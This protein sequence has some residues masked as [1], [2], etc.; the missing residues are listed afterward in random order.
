MFFLD[1]LDDMRLYRRSVLLPINEKDKRH[2]CAAFLLSPNVDSL[3]DIFDNALLLPR[4]YNCYYT[5]KA[6]MYYINQ[7]NVVKEFAS[8][9][10]TEDAYLFDEKEFK[11]HIEGYSHQVG[12]VKKYLK[13]SWFIKQFNCFSVNRKKVNKDINIIIQEGNSNTTKDMIFLKPTTSYPKQFKSYDNYCYFNAYMWIFYQMNPNI[14]DWLCMGL[15]LKEAGVSSMYSRS[16][17]PFNHNLGIICRALDRYEEEHSRIQYINDLIRADDGMNK[18]KISIRDLLSLLSKDIQ[19]SLSKTFHFEGTISVSDHMGIVLEDS[20]YNTTFKKMLYS[21]RIKSNKELMTFYEMIK[22]RYPEIK[23]C[24]NNLSLYGKRNLFIDLSYYNNAFIQ[25]CTAIKIK[26][27]NLYIDLLKRLFSDKRFA[28]AGYDKQTVII[29]VDS[30]MRSIGGVKDF[31]LI[32]KTINPISVIFLILSNNYKRLEDIFG[33]REVLFL[34]KSSFMKVNFSKIDDVKKQMFL[35]NIRIIAENK[36]VLDP[37]A[38]VG[39]AAVSSAKAIKMTIVDN[40]EKARKI[41]IDNISVDN[42]DEEDEDGIPNIKVEDIPDKEPTEDDKKKQELVKV[43]DKASKSQ[44]SVEDTLDSIDANKEDAERIKNIISDLATNPDNGGNNISGARASR[45]LKLQNDFMDSE[46]EGKSIKDILDP[47]QSIE[48]DIKPISL[49]IDSINPEWKELKFAAT[50]ESYNLDDDIVRIFSSFNDKSNPLVVLSLKKDDTSTSGNIIDTYTCKYESAKGE[51]FTVKVD[52]PRF[53]DNK[54]MVLRGN[55]KNIPIQIFLMPIIKTQEDTVQIVSCY[56]KI[57]IRRFGTTSGKSNPCTDKLM[58]ALRKEYKHI[59]I[60][61]G[62]N[63]RVCSKYEVPI[64][65]VDLAGEYT[66]IETPMYVFM[67]NQDQIHSK[68]DI[69]DSDGLCIGYDK[70]SKNP[71]FFKPD[72]K[73][74]MF[75]SQYI[76]LMM[77]T[78]LA[79]TNERDTFIENFNNANTAVRYTFSRAKVM[80]SEIPLI[81]ICALAEGLEKVMRKAHIKYELSEKRPKYDHST[82]DIIRFKDGF[83]K[84]PLDYASCL[85]MN[86]LKQCNTEDYSLTNINSRPM[87]IDF[88]DM[89]GGRAKADGLDNFADCMIDPITKE[90]LTHYKLPTDYVSVLLHANMLLSDNKMVKHGDI[91]A[92]RRFR[93]KEQIA[94]YLYIVLCDAYESYSSGLKK[95]RSVGFSIK[96]SAVIDAVLL[97]NTTNDQSI[98]NPLGEYEAYY[99]ATPQ[100]PSGMNSERSYGLDKRSY[101]ESMLNVLSSATGHANTVGINRQTTIDANISGTRGYIYNDPSESDKKEINSVKTLCMTESIVP[102]TSTRDDPFRLAMG[103]VQ[104]TKHTMVSAK[105]DPLLISSG[106]D[107][108]LPYLISNTFAYKAKGN[109]KVLEI[110]QDEYMIIE[111]DKPVGTDTQGNEILHEYIDLS[112]N[113]EKNSSSGF[114]ITLKLDTDLKEGRRFKTNDIIAYDKKSFSNEVGKNDT[115]AYN[116]GTLSK[117]AILTCDECFEDSVII[118][119][120]VSEGMATD[121]VLEVEKIIPKGANVYNLVKKGQE[122]QEGDNLMILQNAYDEDDVNTLLK[123]INGEEDTITDLGRIPIHSKVTGVVQ[124]IVIERTVDISE[125]SPTLKKIVTEYESGIN[126]K[127]KVMKNYDISDDNKT[128]QA[129]EKLPAI[130]TLKNAAE[131]VVI[132]FYLKYRDKFAVGCKLIF[133]SALKGVCKDIFP[134]GKEPYSEY[135]KKEKI[136]AFLSTSSVNARMVGSVIVSGGINKGLIELSRK[137]KEMAGLPIEDNLL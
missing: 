94:N 62:D 103:Y 132:K 83:I 44:N 97:G 96:Q 84:Y 86:G 23:Y 61:T 40:V 85:L 102:F 73:N 17:W 38:T 116:V 57:F 71:I 53:I 105:S 24:Y 39:G 5:E 107:E 13:D 20:K 98:L 41:K 126:K 18:L 34:G 63:S 69:K 29:P 109:G 46:F 22:E 65:Y 28:E 122:I 7:D 42:E 135:R 4:Y 70:K 72:P 124:D 125:L 134:V 56:S 45:M 15:A 58:K 59:K 11:I 112:E 110:V 74:P 37:E 117:F 32:G 100:G 99:M 77:E 30:W 66:K 81:V 1:E 78:S 91:R 33:N 115:L 131:S 104:N 79:N 3:E 111:Y 93:S 128:I 89:F 31:H 9:Y 129:T 137:V 27:A 118:S 26:G 25:N 6:V 82:E 87:Y 121:I 14:D 19:D 60:T 75:L 12:E 120:D 64:D 80:N 16:D 113:V 123:N 49:N 68:F 119:N 76:Y 92:S 88:L 136:H 10:V 130:G 54:Y 101:D 8:E 95:G 50:L 106:A 36:V 35:R 21:G 90:T 2:S 114:Y 127:K 43:I 51:R 48:E 133:N 67:F 47:S 108:A 55:R 52:I